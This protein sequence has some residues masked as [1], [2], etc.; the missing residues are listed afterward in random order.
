MDIMHACVWHDRQGDSRP[1]SF[2]NR[3]IFPPN[4]DFVLWRGEEG[5]GFVT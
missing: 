3:V 1:F 5:H 4:L 2:M